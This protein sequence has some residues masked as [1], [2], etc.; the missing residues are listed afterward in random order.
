MS[1]TIFDIIILTIIAA[2]S[3]LGG[4]NGLV[5]LS[6]NFIAFLGS[7]FCAYFL[8]PFMYSFFAKFFASQALLVLLGACSSYI[9]ALIFFSILSSKFFAMVKDSSGGLMD[10]FLGLFAG[11]LRG[12]IVSLLIFVV[13]IVVSCKSYMN[14]ETFYDV[15]Q[16]TKSEQYPQWLKDSK[17]F[18]YLDKFGKLTLSLI[19]EETIKS[20]RLR[21]KPIGS[22][23]EEEYEVE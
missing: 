18:E 15:S 4:Y 20:M 22:E 7:I 8:Y 6:I 19:P 14:A 11:F 5:R 12:S 16:N 1:F 21:Q 9:V 13:I 17:V 2:S 3:M 23:L 10:R